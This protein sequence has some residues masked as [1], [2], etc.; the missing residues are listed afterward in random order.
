MSAKPCLPRASL[1][2]PRQWPHSVIPSM[3]YKL[4]ELL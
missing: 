4:K 3:T 2:L 1:D